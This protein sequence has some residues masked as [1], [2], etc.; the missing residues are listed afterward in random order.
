MRAVSRLLIRTMGH[1]KT[2]YFLVWSSPLLDERFTSLFLSKNC[3][4]HV[5]TSSKATGRCSTM[6]R[7]S[8]ATFQKTTSS[9]QKQSRKGTRE[10]GLSTLI[11]QKSWRAAPV[12]RGTGLELW[13]LWRS[14]FL[15]AD[16]TLT[17]MIW[18]HSSTSFFG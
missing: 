11:W 7:Y 8:T 13:N 5:A 18:S 4:R 17:G 3:L 14:R 12:E 16:R 15:K 6:E 1:S 2:G 10:A 9:L